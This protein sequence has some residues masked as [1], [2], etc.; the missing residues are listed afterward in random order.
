MGNVAPREDVAGEPARVVRSCEG[1]V[2]LHERAT[3]RDDIRV[4]SR[5]AKV[6]VPGREDHDDP[7][8]N[9]GGDGGGHGLI[10]GAQWTELDTAAPTA[11]DDRSRETDPCA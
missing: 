6:A 8:A 3:G 11:G 7:R 9:S 5:K 4:L 2:L 10:G 1:C